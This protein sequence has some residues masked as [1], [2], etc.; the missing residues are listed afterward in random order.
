MRQMLFNGSAIRHAGLFLAISLAALPVAGC[1]SL[2]FNDLTG[3]ISRDEVPPNDP[4]GSLGG[5]SSRLIEPVRSLKL[6]LLHPATGS[7][8]REM[9]RNR[10]AWRIADPLKSIWRI[11]S[12]EK[13]GSKKPSLVRDSIKG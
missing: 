7:A 3:S 1:K 6:R 9:A 12:P 11:I 10:P 5:T 8:A 4:A 2:S 13:T